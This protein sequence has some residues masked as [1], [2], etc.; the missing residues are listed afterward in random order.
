MKTG[1]ID[2]QF[3]A[4]DKKAHPGYRDAIGEMQCSQWTDAW[5]QEIHE[6]MGIYGLD[7]IESIKFS[8]PIK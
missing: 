5:R 2:Q 3:N 8:N 1:K 7:W 4:L 6:S